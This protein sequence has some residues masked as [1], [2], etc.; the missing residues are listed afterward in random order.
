MDAEFFPSN[1]LVQ[2]RK[3]RQRDME[4]KKELPS[5]V[6]SDTRSVRKMLG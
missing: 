3:I 2:E 5:V 6:V 4:I 1:V